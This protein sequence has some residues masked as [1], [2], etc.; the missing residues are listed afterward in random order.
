M[1]KPWPNSTTDYAR[2]TE[3]PLRSAYREKDERPIVFLLP[4]LSG[5]IGELA[6]L[7]ARIEAPLR[8]VPITYR[9]WTSLPRETNEFDQ[10]VAHC[11]KQIESYGPPATIFLAGYSFGGQMAWAVARAMVE[12]RHRAVLLG[13][14]DAR[15][16][17]DIG[18]RP[19]SNAQR[20][21][22]FIRGVRSG[23]TIE[24]LA[25]FSASALYRPQSNW[26]RAAFA[27]LY[28]FGLWPSMLRLIDLNIQIRFHDILVRECSARMAASQER[29]QYP[30][31]LF[32]GASPAG[33][34]P[35]PYLGWSRFLAN[36]RVVQIPGNHQSIMQSQNAEE[37]IAQLLEVIS[38]GDR[39]PA[40]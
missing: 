4:G 32:R 11:V 6:S 1:T 40:D 20:W 33:E 7:V 15:A 14:I 23:E 5:D 3:M 25:R 26:A 16:N 13:L 34:D 37:M 29:L 17:P 35:D 24:Q 12:A 21:N 27:R 19:A 39:M 22:R 28:G 9:H 2:A 18:D 30:A 38:E 36:L 31:V 8:F 10:L